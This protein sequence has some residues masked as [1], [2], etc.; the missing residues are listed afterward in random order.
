M[1]DD[2][3]SSE[4]IIRGIAAQICE[5][6]C[7][8]LRAFDG[9]AAELLVV[10]D[11]ESPVPVEFAVIS[12]TK[13]EPYLVRDPAPL[14]E[15]GLADAEWDTLERASARR[16]ASLGSAIAERTL[17]WP[18]AG[19]RRSACGCWTW[20]ELR[21]SRGRMARRSRRSRRAS[22]VSCRP[23]Y[24]RRPVRVWCT[25]EAARWRCGSSLALRPRSFAVTVARASASCFDRWGPGQAGLPG[26]R[27]RRR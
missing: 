24:S 9:D 13:D 15:L 7:P 14:D 16:M 18:M 8:F 2:L 6:L 21:F 23:V 26:L 20:Q 11:D 25:A 5:W 17:G 4:G 1:S 12:A 10:F 27:S 19:R 3:T 22:M